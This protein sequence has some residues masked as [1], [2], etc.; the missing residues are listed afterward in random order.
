LQKS[1][2]YPLTLEFST[3]AQLSL[4]TPG[5]FGVLAK[6]RQLK[7]WLGFIEL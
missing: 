5:V 4:S 1:W 3:S 7:N 6:N 2:D